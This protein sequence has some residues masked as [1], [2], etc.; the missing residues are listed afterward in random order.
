MLVFPREFDIFNDFSG[1]TVHGLEGLL[2]FLMR[3]IGEFQLC[4]FF[5]I[6]SV[7]LDS[8]F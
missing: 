1:L 8:R 6:I 7:D 5:V 2:I 3:V 4:V